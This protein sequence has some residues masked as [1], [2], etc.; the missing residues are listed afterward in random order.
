[1]ENIDDSWKHLKQIKAKTIENKIDI[2]TKSLKQIFTHD[3]DKPQ[4]SKERTQ[5]INHH[6][7]TNEK[8]TNH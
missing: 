8:Y 5:T 1:M 2:L 3:Q 6:V 7:K 4:F